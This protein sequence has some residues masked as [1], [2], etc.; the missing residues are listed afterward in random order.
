MLKEKLDLFVNKLK[1]FRHWSAVII[2]V[3]VLIIAIGAVQAS[4]PV[5]TLQSPTKGGWEMPSR[6]WWPM[7]PV[8]MIHIVAVEKNASVTIKTENF[9]ESEDFTITMGYIYTRGK[10]G[11]IVDEFNSDTGEPQELTFEIPEDL[12]DQYRVAIR[13]QTDHTFPYYAFNWFFN[14]STDGASTNGAQVESTEAGTESSVEEAETSEET[15]EAIEQTAID[16]QM[17]AVNEEVPSFEICEVKK[18]E[19]VIIVTSDF[20]EEKLFTVKMGVMPNYPN[21][22]NDYDGRMKPRDDMAMGGMHGKPPHPMPPMYPTDKDKPMK[23]TKIWIPYYEAGIFESGDG[24]ELTEGFQI[25]SPLIG[26]YRIS[27]MMYTDDEY[28]YYSYNWFY[29]NDADPSCGP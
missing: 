12:H 16:P 6:P 3:L 28:P 20:P 7:A 25:P 4:S 21:A 10:D 14:N 22:E 24:G 26:A 17:I 2:A 19:A 8:P 23:P 5:R 18:N 9:P 27:I 1:S 15:T 11:I 13:A 29:N